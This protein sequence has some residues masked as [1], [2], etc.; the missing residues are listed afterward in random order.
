[1]L[2]KR[3]LN[4]L[5]ADVLQTFRQA[6]SF[7]WNIARPV[8][9]AIKREAKKANDPNYY[10]LRTDARTLKVLSTRP[11]RKAKQSA[12]QDVGEEGVE[13]D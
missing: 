13:W 11:K 12:D 8:L 2:L 3:T 7:P 4:D 10:E 1:L 5:V 6:L 9:C